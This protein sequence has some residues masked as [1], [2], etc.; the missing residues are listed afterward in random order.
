MDTSIFSA[1][2]PILVLFGTISLGMLILPPLWEKM[3]DSLDTSKGRM[4]LGAIV[5][6]ILLIIAYSFSTILG[7]ALS[8]F[9]LWIVWSL[10]KE[11]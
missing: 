6:G 4:T 11:A 9:I 10:V 8:A 2:L 3:I 5:G 7:I 1:L